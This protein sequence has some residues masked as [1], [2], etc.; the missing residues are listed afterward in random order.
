ME[1]L[2]IKQA[3]TKVIGPVNF[4]DNFAIRNA[5]DILRDINRRFACAAIIG[6]KAEFWAE[7]LR[8]QDVTLIDESDTLNFSDKKFDLVIHALSLHHCNDPVGQ[9]IQVRQALNPD[10]LML[11]FLLGGQTLLEL[12]ASFEAAEITVKNGISPRIAPMIEIRD[13]GDLLVRSGFALS[14][15]DKSDLEVTYKTPIDLVNDLRGMG[16]TNIMLDRQKSFLRRSIF[17]AMV[18]NYFYNYSIENKTEVEA[19]FSILCL[20]GWAPADNQQKP[21]KPGS[22]KHHFSE[23]LSTYDF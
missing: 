16:E 20:T 13:A 1:A 8:F 11:V 21:L 22:A 19:T 7:G 3:R 6:S 17:N 18:K 10:G 12:R 9:L 4:I 14:V 2:K 5:T 23:V 15:A